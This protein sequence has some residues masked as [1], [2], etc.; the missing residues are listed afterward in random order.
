LWGDVPVVVEHE[1][2]ATQYQSARDV[3]DPQVSNLIRLAVS[4]GAIHPSAAVTNPL[5]ITAAERQVIPGPPLRKRDRIR[6][7][8]RQNREDIL[9]GLFIVTVVV[10]A[11]GAVFI[12]PFGIIFVVAGAG[13]VGGVL[14]NR[15]SRREQQLNQQAFDTDTEARAFLEQTTMAAM[16]SGT[17]APTGFPMQG[18]VDDESSTETEDENMQ[19]FSRLSMNPMGPAAE[20]SGP[21]PAYPL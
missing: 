3:Q 12:S 17:A 6:L 14:A 5:A 10:L 20:P 13:L 16:E 18:S 4:Q 11:A 8:W 19:Q 2:G 7:W 21:K 1:N 15:T 9:T